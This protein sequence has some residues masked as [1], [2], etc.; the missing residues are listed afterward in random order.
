MT[1]VSIVDYNRGNLFS[2]AQAFKHCGADV[3][4]ITTPKE[5]EEYVLKLDTTEL[6]G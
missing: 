1:R 4:F 2:V 6:A 5:I 3:D